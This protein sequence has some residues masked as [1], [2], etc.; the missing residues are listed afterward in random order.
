[1][2]AALFSVFDKTGLVPL[3]QGLQ[4]LGWKLMATGG[5]L[6]TLLGAGLKVIEVADY[7][8]APECF[9]GRVKTLHPRIHGGLLFR[10]ESAAHV[11]DARRLNIEPIDLAVVNLYPFEA[12]IARE[13]VS[14]EECVEQIDIGGPSMLRSAAKNHVSVTVLV[15]P[16]Q[17]D[18]FLEKTRADTWSEADRRACAL[19]VFRRTSAYDAAISAWLERQ[20]Q[21]TQQDGKP[22]GLPEQLTLNLKSA[23]SLRYGENPHQAAGFYTQPGARAEG[24]AACK[25]LQGKEL[26]FNNL[27]DSDGAARVVWQLDEAG[28]V[29]VKHNNPCGIGLAD[30]PTDAFLK[31]QAS[32]P[33]SAFGGIAAFNRP[34]DAQTARAMISAFWEVILAPGFESEALEVFAAKKQLRL[35]ETPDQWPLSANG[36]DLRGIGGGFLLQ[37]PDDAFAPVS[38]WEVKA[39][40]KTPR[41][42]DRDLILAQLAAKAVKSNSIVLVRDGGT[43]GVGAGQM[44]RV[45]SV[46]IACRKAGDRASGAVLGSDAFF[47]FADGLE[48]AAK[49]GVTA[50]IEPGGSVRDNEVI[51]A[52]QK[53]G[54]WLFFTGMRH[55][56]H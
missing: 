29:I 1:M 25:Q 33:V 27:L 2:P 32:D 49:N 41:P 10:R 40:G 46:D 51:E 48:L 23:Q 54:V 45:D 22:D 6:K 18:L 24:I 37:G 50:F 17:Y 31:A 8:G 52:A 38:Q 26:S 36:L 43:V 34:L 11:E 21:L 7:T 3:A 9:D 19:E 12:T 44:S 56:R 13:N 30:S 28:C 35:L 5:T 47:P 20:T 53:L 42:P 55:F 16:A 4:D 39:I 14:F 15:D